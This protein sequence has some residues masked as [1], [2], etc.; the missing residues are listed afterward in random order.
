MTKAV[1]V[2]VG[3]VG[4][5]GGGGGGVRIKVSLSSIPVL[6]P[7]L[8]SLTLPPLFSF[9]ARVS[10]LLGLTNICIYYLRP[11]FLFTKVLHFSSHSPESEG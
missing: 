3:G 9:L 6:D 5:G 7:Y 11:V 4:G 8:S 10:A 1:V 2:F